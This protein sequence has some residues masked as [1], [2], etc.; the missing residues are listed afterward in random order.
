MGEVA[1][2]PAQLN[3]ELPLFSWSLPCRSRLTRVDRVFPS[4]KDSLDGLDPLANQTN[5]PSVASLRRPTS[6]EQRP[7]FFGTTWLGFA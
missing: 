4:P 3:K 2:G 7:T 6:S 5:T 1:E